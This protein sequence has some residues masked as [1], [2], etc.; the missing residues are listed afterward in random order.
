MRKLRLREV[1]ATGQSHR[2]K[3]SDGDPDSDQTSPRLKSEPLHHRGQSDSETILGLDPSQ[4]SEKTS[5]NKDQHTP[6]SSSKNTLT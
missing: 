3:K 1:K 6:D 5:Q 2:V 4:G